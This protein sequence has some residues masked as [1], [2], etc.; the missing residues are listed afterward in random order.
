MADQFREKAQE[1]Q[2]RAR[3]AMSN[4]GDQKE[5]GQSP[6]E[7]KKRG[8]EAGQKAMDRAKQRREND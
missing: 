4:K 1:L 7:M 8:K 5:K 2:E 6:D 3:D